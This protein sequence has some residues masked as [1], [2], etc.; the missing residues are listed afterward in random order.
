MP[1][2]DIADRKKGIG[3]S[4]TG[5]TPDNKAAVTVVGTDGSKYSPETKLTVDE[6]G[7]VSGTYFFSVTDNAKVPSGNYSLYLTDEKTEKDSSKV[8]FEVVPSDSDIDDDATGDNCE[9]AT[10]P[11][12]KPSET[13]TD[14]PSESASPPPS[15]TKTDEPSKTA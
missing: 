15:E 9:S 14:D 2:A 11:A 13:K 8:S 6:E 12:P 3:F 10:G 4:G 1:R 5:F 7:K